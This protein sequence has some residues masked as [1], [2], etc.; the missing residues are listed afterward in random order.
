[1]KVTLIGAG[2]RQF[3]GTMI[4]DLLLSEPIAQQGL[5]IVLMDIAAEPLAEMESYT[6]AVIA[7]LGHA[8]TVSATTELEEAVSGAAFII[9]AIEVDRYH[10]WS[11]DFTIPRTYGFKQVYGENGGPGGL[12][13]ALRQFTPLLEIARAIEKHAP[14]ALFL[15][16]SNP[17]H[18]VCEAISRL[19]SVKVVGLCH[20][21]FMGA[22]QISALLDRPREEL[23]LPAAGINHF[24]WF[25]EV[26]DRATGEDLYPRLREI[27]REANWVSDWHEIALSR[28]LFRRFGLWPS[29]SANHIGEY[30]SWAED[31]VP[32]QLQ[33]FH[34]PAEGSPWREGAVTPEWHYHIG[35]VD[36]DRPFHG[37]RTD[38]TLMSLE[39]SLE[40]RPLASSEELAIPIIEWVGCGVERELPAVNVPNRGAIPGLPD[41]MVVE[42]PARVENGELVPMQMQPL[43]EGVLA[44]IQRQ[45]SIHRLLVEAYQEQSKDKLLQAILLDPI[46]DSHNRAV[47]MLDEFLERQHDALPPLR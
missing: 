28:I 11:Q 17:E 32:A 41:E 4:R 6:R 24:Q 22:R 5:D 1:M 2:S 34:D 9:T 13:H 23:Y 46:V 15:N 36:T 26:R 40:D 37:A 16:F 21:Y 18:K 30:I 43:P 31:Y 25:Q 42:V 12:F 47:A 3:A 38:E 35:Q 8:A 10:Y 33:Y 39:A 19:T 44:M 20:G 29:P 7:R 27:E 14:D 45:G